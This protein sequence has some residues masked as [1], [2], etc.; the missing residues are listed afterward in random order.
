MK[1]L[2][3]TH[4]II[5]SLAVFGVIGTAI[6]LGASI[7]KNKGKTPEQI[8]EEKRLKELAKVEK[9]RLK[10]LSKKTDKTAEEIAEENRLKANSS[11][12]TTTPVVT[13]VVSASSNPFGSLP[14]GASSCERTVQ[15]HDSAWDYA[16]CSGTWFTKRKGSNSWTSLAGNT[17][18]VNKLEAYSGS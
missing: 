14:N 4:K 16:K 11:T 7:I 18:A 5:I 2:T 9:N 10:E 15:N 6:W 3:K 8:A 17:V 13:P 1:K 12:T